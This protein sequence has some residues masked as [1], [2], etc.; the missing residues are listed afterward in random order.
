MK[1]R[2]LEIIDCSLFVI[3]LCGLLWSLKYSDQI[4]QLI[5]SLK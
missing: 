2:I 5:I 3:I 1:K 4:N